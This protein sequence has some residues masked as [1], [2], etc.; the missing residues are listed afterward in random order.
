MAV[1]SGEGKSL[2]DL[3]VT[4][5]EIDVQTL[6]QEVELKVISARDKKKKGLSEAVLWT[7]GRNIRSPL[8]KFQI[9]NGGFTASVSSNTINI[10][11]KRWD[12]WN[13]EDVPSH[14]SGI[15][16]W[17][18]RFFKR[19]YLRLLH[20]FHNELLRKQR[21]INAY[22]AETL[23]GLQ[24]EVEAQKTR[25]FVDKSQ[26]HEGLEVFR[27]FPKF[28]VLMP[29]WNSEPV[30]LRKA[31]LSVVQQRYPFWKLSICDDGSDREDFG[32]ILKEYARLD[33]RIHLTSLS[34]HQGIAAATNAALAKA[35]GDFVGFLDHD[36]ELDPD[37]LWEAARWIDQ[38]PGI[39]LLYTDE[40]HLSS[41][42]KVEPRLKPSWSPD[43]LLGF[44]YICHF[45]VLRISFLRELG[46]LHP[47]YEGA[48][49]YDLLLRATEKAANIK[50]IPRILYHWRKSE[51][52]VS[53]NMNVKPQATN[54][55]QRALAAAL[56]RRG[57]KG[58]VEVVA[59]GIYRVKRALVG[60][61]LISIVILS[62][63]NVRDL[64]NCLEN[65]RSQ[66][67]YRNYEIIIVDN[68]SEERQTTSY[69]SSL[70][71]RILR[72]EGP[73]NFSRLNN[74]GARQARG[75][76]LLFLNDDT[77]VIAPD[78]LEAMLE[79]V[80]RKE[81]GV[82]G[83]K[84]IF[85]NG[86]VQHAG[87]VLNVDGRPT[88]HIF[89]GANPEDWGYENALRTVRNYSAVT[90][91]CLMIRRG[92]FEEVGGFDEQYDVVFGDVDLCLKV[93]EKGFLVVWTPFALLQ[94][95]EF[96]TRPRNQDPP[97]DTERFVTRWQWVLDQGDPYYNPNLSVL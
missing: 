23:R 78:W 66:S 36:D 52:S 17:V 48:Q 44:N 51:T 67:T 42:M 32:S 6:M 20:P 33:E 2:G 89:V 54:S 87:I 86:T 4:P 16:G 28:T 71:D 46:G 27:Y 57:I 68:G 12:I 25:A 29:V 80:Q 60:S 56:E 61:P 22:F 55:G 40:D 76:V 69:L 88:A 18:I 10:F 9:P 35:S 1:N 39:D 34:S 81:V 47:G 94:H 3:R 58:K 93:R 73:F 26:G 59:Q 91:A 84:L 70:P 19:S 45:V 41:E 62:R 83:A 72:Y 7:F 82:V 15:G 13:P 64:R 37:T 5:T 85:P 79:Q 75:E 31:I 77:K 74:L 65:I 96:G 97:R 43:L 24:K 53:A 11:S 63:D 49:D 38:D 50:R 95:R 90:G 92:V 21:T 14:R 30:Y 8:S